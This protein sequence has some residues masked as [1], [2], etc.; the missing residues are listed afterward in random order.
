MLCTGLR[1]VRSGY[2]REWEYAGET[3]R[4]EEKINLMYRNTHFPFTIN[5]HTILMGGEVGTPLNWERKV[6]TP[7][8]SNIKPWGFNR[9]ASLLVGDDWL[10]VGLLFR[11]HYNLIELNNLKVRINTSLYYSGEE[12]NGNLHMENPHFNRYRLSLGLGFTFI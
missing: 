5:K 8:Q 11:I 12:H 3:G 1:F 9:V 10:D 6:T 4:V 2:D 7:S